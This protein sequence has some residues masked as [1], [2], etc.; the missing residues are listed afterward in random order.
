MDP[1]EYV[2]CRKCG[3]PGQRLTFTGRWP[4]SGDAGFDMTNPV[5]Y[6]CEDCEKELAEK[7]TTQA[8]AVAQLTRIADALEKIAS[9]LE[10]ALKD[11]Q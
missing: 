10:S 9:S 2:R 3:S 4:S 8:Q 7:T 6:E 5:I 11:K 1:T